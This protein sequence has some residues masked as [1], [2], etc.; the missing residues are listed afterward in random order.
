MVLPFFR[1][2][3][4]EPSAPPKQSGRKAGVAQAVD[5]YQVSALDFTGG[6]ARGLAVAAGKIRV[7]EGSDIDHPAIEEAAILFANNSDDAAIVVLEAALDS[8]A[9]SNE[10]LWQ[11]LF[12]LCRV[13]GDKDLFEQ[14][15]LLY[16]TQ[17][18]RSPPIWNELAEKKPVK[19]Q[20][21]DAMPSVGLTGN[22]G[23]QAASQF[24]QVRKVALKA[25]KLK[26][27]LARVRGIDEAGCTLLVGLLRD[28]R[29]AKVKVQIANARTMLPMVEGHVQPGRREGQSIWLIV[30]ELLQVLQ[31]QERFEEVALDYAITFEESPP[32]YET[33]APSLGAT[34]LSQKLTATSP[35]ASDV[36]GELE[37]VPLETEANNYTFEG[38]L[39]SAQAE[40]IRK[41]ATYGA[42]RSTVEVDA[43]RLLRIDFV[44]A[45]NLFN[46]LTQF[47]TQGK[48]CVIRGL[49]A[50]VAALLR[51]MGVHHVA[52]MEEMPRT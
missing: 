20:V 5:P 2:S 6:D 44:S 16:A 18:N 11:M 23:A 25:G 43:S 31:E 22:L 41:L 34:T 49:N 19:A 26:I 3:G 51:V 27:D 48:H 50:M 14:R 12:D 38:T 46:V 47:Q 40:A 33:S 35:T 10:T 15:G 28:L 4:S 45:G 39:S 9:S 7:D 52:Q 37:L 13:T 42:E 29:Q 30:L 1:K 36:S 24:E 8:G 21:R 17:F 32:S